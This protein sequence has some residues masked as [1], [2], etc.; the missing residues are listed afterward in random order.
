MTDELPPTWSRERTDAYCP[1]PDASSRRFTTY[2]HESG[3]VALRVAPTVLDVTE[4]P[5]YELTVTVY[6]ELEF[7]SRS[8]VRTVTTYERCER[9]AR[10][11]MHFFEGAYERPAAVESAVEHAA[12]HV[13]PSEAHD[14][15]VLDATPPG[16]GEGGR[17]RV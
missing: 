9:V 13:R 2:R 7:S 8:V 1:T 15:V 10:E 3:D 14:D 12:A 16:A 6:P 5:G 4:R 11:F 17:E